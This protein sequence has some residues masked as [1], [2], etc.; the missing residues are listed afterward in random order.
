MKRKNK[1]HESEPEEERWKI[2]EVLD[3]YPGNAVTEDGPPGVVFQLANKGD[4]EPP[5]VMSV[6][7]AQT[8]VTKILV[9]LASHEC[10]F[11]TKLIE[12]HFVTVEGVRYGGETS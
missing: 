10:P 2:M 5:M 1:N 3:C 9:A 11:A 8:F 12:Q 6:T 7:D 4:L